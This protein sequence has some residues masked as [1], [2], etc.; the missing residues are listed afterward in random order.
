MDNQTN[1]NLIIDLIFLQ[2]NSLELN[3]H[4]IYPEWRLSSDHVPLTIDIA[5]YEEY[6][7]T[8]KY[9][10]VKNSEEEN[11]FLIKLIETIK[12]LDTEYIS[13]K[14]ILENTVQQFTNNTKKFGSNIQKSSISQ[15]TQN[16]SEMRSVK[17]NLRVIDYQEFLR[18]R[19]NSEKLSRR[20]NICFSILKSK[21][22]QQ[23]IVVHENL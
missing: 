1:S 16:H 12:G 23:N 21:K 9:T 11:N 3:N 15:S 5:I 20:L 17:G 8:K 10:I 6:I 19:R 18:T 4:T 22:L 14:E 7:Q 2:P 13:S